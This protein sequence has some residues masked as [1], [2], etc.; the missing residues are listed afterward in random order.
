MGV[1]SCREKIKEINMEFQTEN[2]NG[3]PLG[4]HNCRYKETG[5]IGMGYIMM[6]FVIHRLILSRN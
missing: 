3:R 5:H 2:L 4:R 6:N 1:A